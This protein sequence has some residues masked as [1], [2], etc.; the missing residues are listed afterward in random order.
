MIKGI[1]MKFVT[2]INGQ[3]YMV[4]ILEG[5]KVEVNGV[6]HSIDFKTIKKQSLYSLLVD[7]QSFEANVI[8]DGDDLEI[9]LNGWKFN[10]MVVDE[11]VERMR[12]STKIDPGQTGVSVLKAP[13][14]GMVVEVFVAEG[15]EVKRGDLLLVLESMKMQNELKSPRTGKVVQVQVKRN[16]SVEQKETLLIIE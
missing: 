4:E 8:Q 2:N 3:K 11:R 9:Y 14:P 16:D 1:Q 7:N 12:K 15:E 13:M 10:A 6:T 5:N